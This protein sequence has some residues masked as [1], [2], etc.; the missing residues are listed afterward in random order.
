MRVA[1]F[2]LH[3][4][5]ISRGEGRSVVAA[6]AYRAGETLPNEGEERI[7]AFGGRRDV[8]Y[9][10]IRLPAL[11]PAWMSDRAALWNAVEKCEIRKDARLA[12]EIE[13]A[14]PRELPRNEWLALVREFADVYVSQ[15]FIV[16]L[17]IHDDGT[18]QNP[19]AHL[20]LTTR[21][22]TEEGFG[23]KVRAA[24]G[25]A[26]V[27]E[28]RKLWA[29]ITNATFAKGG[30]SLAINHRSHEDSGIDR[31]PGRHRG[32]VPAERRARR[33]AMP[34]IDRKALRDE[35]LGGR[36]P[37]ER[38]VTTIAIDGVERQVDPTMSGVWG[39]A[40]WPVEDVP[41]PGPH[42][43]IL[44]RSELDQA[45][46][47]MI[48]DMERDI[49]EDR[50]W[51]RKREGEGSREAPTAERSWFSRRRGEAAEEG[52]EVKQRRRHQERD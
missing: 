30:S 38:P 11:A 20:L 40:N 26:F 28:A 45:Q 6:A 46:T 24:D 36:Q 19:H 43:E 27:L 48:S 33:Q 8:L 32:P 42:G 52:M 4:K 7:S 3:V 29:K 5:N 50:P 1:I 10:E 2:H 22:L 49:H 17:A 51:F 39:Q 41:E 34:D 14:L 23:P 25:K 37:A 21:V 44:S 31:P 47:A 16:D 9:A 15:G 12:K 13:V 18:L 35:L